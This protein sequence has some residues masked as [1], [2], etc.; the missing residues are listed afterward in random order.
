M[1]QWYKNNRRL[2]REERMAMA[3]VYPL[4]RLAVVY[5]GF[6]LNSVCFLKQ[7]CAVVHGIYS[8]SIPDSNRQIDYRIA[9]VLPIKYPKISPEMFCNDPKLP[10][11]EIDRHIMKNGSACLGVRADIGMR[12]AAGPTI[13]EFLEN[14]VEPFLVWQAYYDAY[15][16]PPLW[17]EFSHDKNGIIEFYAELL[18]RNMDSSILGFMKLLAR[19]NRPKGHEPCPCN[20]GKLLRNCHRDLIY[21]IRKRVAWQYVEKDLQDLIRADGNSGSKNPRPEDVILISH[22]RSV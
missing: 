8:L 13:V 10:I 14:I 5:P 21:D 15:K 2:F 19:K 11:G 17:G 1:P 7:E 9:L 18:G 3:S 6:K 4:L 12:W 20:S 22:R 16:K